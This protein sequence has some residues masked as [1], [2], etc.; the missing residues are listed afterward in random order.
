MGSLELNIESWRES[1]ELI[2]IQYCMAEVLQWAHCSPILDCG[3]SPVGSLEFNIG[4][5]K[6]YVGLI[7]GQ[8]WTE[9]GVV[10]SLH[11]NIEL[12]REFC[13]LIAVQ[14]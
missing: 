5:W 2:G 1:G 6:E 3:G 10:G 11:L 13:E 8:Y 4:L 14:H 9:E 7:G 12:Q